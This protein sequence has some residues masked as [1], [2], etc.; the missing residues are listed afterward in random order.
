MVYHYRYDDVIVTKEYV[1]A[2]VQQDGK[3]KEQ[4]KTEFS[5][6]PATSKKFCLYME[7]KAGSFIAIKDF[8]G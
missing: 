4:T 2:Q 3:W 5:V 8:N 1:V 6:L 7:A